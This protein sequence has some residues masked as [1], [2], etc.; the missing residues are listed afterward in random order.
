MAVGVNPIEAFYNQTIIYKSLNSGNKQPCPNIVKYSNIFHGVSKH[1][2]KIDFKLHT[3]SSLA[4]YSFV[5]RTEYVG[6]TVD[7]RLVMHICKGSMN[8][9]EIDC[10]VFVLYIY[11]LC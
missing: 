10:F 4:L 7:G 5:Q 6:L 8:N 1:K 9:S 11:S 2:T 3:F